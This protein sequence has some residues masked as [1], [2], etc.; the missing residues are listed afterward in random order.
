MQAMACAANA[1]LSSTTSTSAASMPAR[2]SAL[3]D[4]PTGP[5]PITSGAQ[6]DTA[7][8]FTRTRGSSPCS[9]AYASLHTTT[10]AAPSVS[11]DEVPAVTV[12][13]SRNTGARSASPSRLVS[14]RMQPS[15]SMRAPPASTGTISSS[16]RP[17]ARAAAAR[18]WLASANASCSVR[19]IW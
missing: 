7:T 2:S 16:R 8:L 13:S 11:G 1:S 17:S 9:F 15:R 5:I 4:A 6:P 12:P 14:S 10:A 3:R 19:V 18:C